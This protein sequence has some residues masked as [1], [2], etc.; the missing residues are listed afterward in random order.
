[1]NEKIKWQ[2]EKYTYEIIFVITVFLLTALYQWIALNSAGFFFP[3][4]VFFF[5]IY[6]QA[7]LFRIIVFPLFRNKKYLKVIIMT[8]IYLSIA[9]SIFYI[10]CHFWLNHEFHLGK[11]KS[12]KFMIYHVATC[13]ISTII[14]MCLLFIRQYYQEM[15][16][17]NKDQRLLREIKIKLLHAQ[18]NP[19]F[20]FNMFNNLYGVSLTD[21][22]KIPDLILKLSHLMRYPLENGDKR[23]VN[24]KDEVEYI[25]SYIEME[26]VRV[27]KR[28]EITLSLP[29]NKRLLSYYQIAPLLLITLVEN[30]FK[31]SQ[32]SR[33]SWFIQL[34]FLLT[35]NEFS[36]QI[37]NS[38]S[39]NDTVKQSLGMGL[40][41]ISKRLSL[42][43]SD[44]YTLGSYLS[45]GEYQTKLTLQLNAL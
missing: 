10:M 23:F 19:H 36:M 22:D 16:K 30:A 39:E 11:R 14:L 15:E 13:C 33:G 6:L 7:Q 38:V 45:N 8:V 26:R 28:C 31:H 41:I 27:G 3:A 12:M 42:L 25:E 18:L 20:F 5:I 34:H 40:S 29:Q 1:M 9:I 24:L 37:I 4:V 17:R 21:P 43:Y 2:I 32:G 35:G 44:K